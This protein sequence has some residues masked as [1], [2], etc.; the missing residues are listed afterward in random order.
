[1]YYTHTDIRIDHNVLDFLN[2]VTLLTWDFIDILHEID[3]V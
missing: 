3:T 2:I 1:M